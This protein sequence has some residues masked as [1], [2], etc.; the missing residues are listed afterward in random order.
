[1]FS[2]FKAMAIKE[3]RETLGITLVVLGVCVLLF[4]G[5][6]TEAFQ[7]FGTNAYFLP[8]Y[9]ECGKEYVPFVEDPLFVS[10]FNWICAAMAI[11]LGFRQT[12][13]ESMHG[14][15]LFLFH[16]PTDRCRLIG[17]KLLVGL[18]MYLMCGAVG[19]TVY[20]L[21]AATPGKHVGPF[22]W[23]MTETAWMALLEMTL[24]YFSAFLSGI[25]PG[26]WFGTRLLPLAAVI[27]LTAN[28]FPEPFRT[29]DALHLFAAL[30]AGAWM[31]V[32][33]LFVARTRDYS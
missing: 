1:M 17:V 19:I 21:W 26:R 2:M 14:T 16:R 25:R 13:G 28:V 22:E 8:V 18:A 23:S 10:R 32:A 6:L 20:G 3:L 24:F 4:G 5:A 9:H 31:I 33:I 27:P 29:G 7:M 11:A 12:V 15:Y 30:A